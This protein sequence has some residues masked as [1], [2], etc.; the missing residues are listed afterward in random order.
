[1]D[2]IGGGDRAE[3]LAPV[4]CKLGM[5]GE[6]VDDMVPALR[7]QFDASAVWILALTGERSQAHTDPV[8]RAAEAAIRD[9]PRVRAPLRILVTAG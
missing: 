2:L 9:G 5:A 3:N 1:L 6:L 4:L 7:G 8:A